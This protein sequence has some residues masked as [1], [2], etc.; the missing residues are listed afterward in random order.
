LSVAPKKMIALILFLEIK[1]VLCCLYRVFYVLSFPSKFVFKCL[2][3][4]RFFKCHQET[5]F[6]LLRSKNYVAFNV[7][8]FLV[9]K[10]TK[11]ARGVTQNYLLTVM[12]WLSS[13]FVIVLCCVAFP[14][15]SEILSCC[16][17]T[18]IFSNRI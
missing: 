1:F 14:L 13:L 12:K 8:I 9:V 3:Q 5:H 18:R 4:G 17:F 7:Q 10:N 11:F 16:H 2:W 6:S 15:R